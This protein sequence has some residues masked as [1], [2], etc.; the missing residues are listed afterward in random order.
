MS[1]AARVCQDLGSTSSTQLRL[2]LGKVVRCN[3]GSALLRDL[4]LVERLLREV[5]K[6]SPFRSP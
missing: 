2:P 1:D 5:R 4:P 6:P 3:G